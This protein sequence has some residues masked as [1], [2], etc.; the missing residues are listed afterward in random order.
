V[1]NLLFEP[2]PE[3][4]A[5]LQIHSPPFSFIRTSTNP[6]VVLLDASHAEVAGL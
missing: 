5:F 1:I 2:R 4:V 3:V 6:K